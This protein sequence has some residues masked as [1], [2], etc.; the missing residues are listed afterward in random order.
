MDKKADCDQ[1][2]DSGVV[3]LW[4][5]DRVIA[6]KACDCPATRA[7]LECDAANGMEWWNSLIERERAKC[8]HCAGN[9][10]IAADAW[11][12]F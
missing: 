3:L 12:A 6:T 2:K 10:G 9:T 11:A 7:Y 1:C 8:L 4:K 5:D